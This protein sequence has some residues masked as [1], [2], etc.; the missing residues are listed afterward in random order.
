MIRRAIILAA[1]QSKRLRPYTDECPKTLLEVGGKP[2]LEHQLEIFRGLGIDDIHIVV[3]Y[4]A[5]QI[6]A[7]GGDAFTY[8]MNPRYDTTNVL[9]S[10]ACARDAMEEGFYFLHAD[11]LFDP[12]IL[13]ALVDHS[14]SFV[15][16]VQK[17]ECGEEE[18]KVKLQGGHVMEINKT[19]EL[20]GAAGEFIGLAKIGKEHVAS[21]KRAMTTIL[22][23]RSEQAFFEEAIQRLIDHENLV[24]QAMDIGSHFAIEIDFPE[25]LE[26]A[27]HHYAS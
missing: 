3:G 17:K 24:V 11:T 6:Q 19:M 26:Q 5:E 1:G 14:G 18:M 4:R 21:L 27:R 2:I 23:T 20:A 22:E 7:Y 8:H 25:D 12:N 10:L 9:G 13:R 16:A 15:L